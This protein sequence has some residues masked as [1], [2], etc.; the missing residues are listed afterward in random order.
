[1]TDHVFRDEDGVENFSVM[2]V[3]GETDEIRRDHGAAR[4]GL[5]RR[6]LIRALRLQDL[7]LERQID[8]RTFFDGAS[9]NY[10]VL[11]GNPLRRTTMKRFENLYFARVLPPFA[12]LPHGDI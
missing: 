2:D 12:I 11:I 7:V 4:P 8:I 5:D 6:L 9:H 3:E 1:M 10:L